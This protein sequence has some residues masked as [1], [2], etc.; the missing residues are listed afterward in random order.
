MQPNRN[1]NQ[2]TPV[3]DIQRPTQSSPPSQVISPTL[4]RPATMEY[5]RPRTNN[6]NNAPNQYQNFAPQQDM[7][8][9]PTAVPKKSKKGLIITV[10]IVLFLI[11]MGG[12][13]AYYYF[14]VEGKTPVAQETL[15][16]AQTE[17]EPSTKTIE[18]TPEGV[19]LVTA[20][21][22]KQL[23]TTD[24]TQDFS[25]NDVSDSNLGL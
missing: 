5:T 21:I 12:T 10:A 9:A 3:M 11:I 25:A 14:A 13:G 24:D 6:G 8:F 20:E 7:S 15:P 19:D 18:A 23:S 17:T 22:D 16:P 1:Q 4:D 2:P